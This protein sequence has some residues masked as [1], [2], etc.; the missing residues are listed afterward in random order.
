MTTRTRRSRHFNGTQAI[1]S[2]AFAT[3]RSQ[4]N[5]LGASRLFRRH[6]ADWATRHPVLDYRD[7]HD[8]IDAALNSDEINRRSI[9]EALATEAVDDDLAMTATL[10]ALLPRLVFLVNR[11]NRTRLDLNDRC[12]TVLEIASEMILTCRPGTATS[13]Y[14]RRLWCNISKRF[15]RYINAQIAADD[16]TPFHFEDDSATKNVRDALIVEP[17]PMGTDMRLAELCDWVSERAAVDM[18]TARLVV[19]TRAGGVSVDDVLG[20]GSG[21]AHSLRQRRLRAEQRLANALTAA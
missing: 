6:L 12:A 15:G 2:P 10:H 16:L 8:L 11:T 21:S 4:W 14:D 20:S 17:D 1:D 5:E 3:M 19:L 7:G 9:L 18:D 13:W